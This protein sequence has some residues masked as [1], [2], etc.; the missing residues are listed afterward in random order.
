[1]VRVRCRVVFDTYFGPQGKRE[2]NGGKQRKI[3]ETIKR[4]N[5][6]QKEIMRGH[7]CSESQFS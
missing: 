5:E 6:S 4:Q 1:M 2:V 3:Q 7:F